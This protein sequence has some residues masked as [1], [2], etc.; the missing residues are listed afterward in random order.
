M[1]NYSLKFEKKHLELSWS[2]YN[3]EALN[4]IIPK[5]SI[6]SLR[7]DSSRNDDKFFIICTIKN[8]SGDEI[9]FPIE[10]RF[11]FEIKEWFTTW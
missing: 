11:I 10:N 3:N 7:F 6:E 9:E 5:K 1:E 4:I 2:N 8:R